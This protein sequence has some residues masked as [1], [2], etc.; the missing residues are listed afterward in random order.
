MLKKLKLMLNKDKSKLAIDIGVKNIKIVEGFFN[1]KEVIVKNIIEFPTPPNTYED[2]QILDLELLSRAIYIELND[3]DIKTKDVIFTIS[4][5]AFLN[6]TL[7]LPSIN[8]EDIKNMLEFE[9]EQHFPVNLEEYVVQHQIVEKIEED[10]QKSII[11]VSALPKL[12]VEEYLSLTKSLDL[13]P[14]I[15]DMNANS[16]AKLIYEQEKIKENLDFLKEKAV[17]ILD[18]GFNDTNIIILEKGALKFSR[19][20][21]FGSKEIDMGI[22]NSFNLSLEE[23]EIKKLELRELGMEEESVSLDM[24]KEIIKSNLENLYIEIEKIFKYYTSRSSGNEIQA[25]YLYGATSKTKGLKEYIELNFEMPT[26]DLEDLK[27]VDDQ[28]NGN[29]NMIQYANAIGALIRK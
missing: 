13:N 29:T 21:D 22:A 6:R 5:N 25:I 26:C 18:I 20:I 9:T 2:G 27:V 10:P 11:L 12:I 24:I 1:G 8:D 28:T 23:A 15:L 14:F 19:I 3:R 16:I 4:S 17:A 7:E